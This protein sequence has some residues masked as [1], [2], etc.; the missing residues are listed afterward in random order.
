MLYFPLAAEPSK[1]G[2]VVPEETDLPNGTETILVVEDETPIRRVAVRTLERSG[3]TVISAADGEE[4]L[5]VFRQRRSDIDL[6][7]TDVMM[8]R[9]SG[10]Q[11]YQVILQEAKNVKFMF[12]SGYAPQDMRTGVTLDPTIP[13]LIKPWTLSEF[14]RQ[15]RGALDGSQRPP[16]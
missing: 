3:Y 14:L 2:S 5:E 11:M 10:T 6:V 4:G 16:M 1:P 7:I 9:M 12:T 13:Y 15:V 8:P